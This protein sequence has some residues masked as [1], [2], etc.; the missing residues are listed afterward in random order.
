MISFDHFRQE[1]LS[2]MDQATKR[3]Q[4]DIVINALELHVAVGVFPNPR[5]QTAADAME[6]ERKPGDVVLVERG[7]VTG[8]TI[9][10][11]LP[12]VLRASRLRD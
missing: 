8:L 5:N 12:R 4:K 7:N 2:Q 6:A 3:G 9:R 11:L 10:Y 1:L